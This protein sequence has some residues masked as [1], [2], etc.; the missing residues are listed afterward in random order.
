LNGHWIVFLIAATAITSLSLFFFSMTIFKRKVM[1]V[2]M[3][4]S[5]AYK[6]DVYI[7][8]AII[9]YIMLGAIGFI[10]V[11]SVYLSEHPFFMVLYLITLFLLSIDRPSINKMSTH[12]VLSKSESKELNNQMHNNTNQSEL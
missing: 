7:N 2:N 10:S 9:K 12:L 8:A 6:T 1:K 3:G 11:F 5:L 4:D